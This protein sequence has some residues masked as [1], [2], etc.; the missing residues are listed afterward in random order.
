MN[1][2]KLKLLDPGAHHGFPIK[3]KYASAHL[4]F[5]LYPGTQAGRQVSSVWV[6]SLGREGTD[7][8]TLTL[9]I[10]MRSRKPD[11]RQTWCISLPADYSDASAC[12]KSS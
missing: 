12:Q 2:Q 4:M 8:N 10:A 3:F 5:F 1:A 11:S 9:D 6:H 7:Y